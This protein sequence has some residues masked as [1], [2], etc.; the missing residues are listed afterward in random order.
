MSR[1]AWVAFAAISVI[2]GVPYLFIK[3][4]VRGG[5]AP[6]PL[7]FARVAM[8]AVLLLVLAARR[9]SLGA[10]RGRWRWL[11]AYA[12]CE[13]AG[14]FPLIAFGEQRIASSLAAILIAAVP[15][16]GALLAIRFDRSERATGSRALGL[17]VGFLGVIALMGVNVGRGGG[18]VVGT[19]AVLLAAVGY[20]IG[21]MIIKLRLAALDPAAAMGASL[22]IA[23]V[24]LAPGAAV[25][26]PQRVPSAQALASVAVLGVACTAAA[27]VIFTLLIREAGTSRALV[28]TY[29][30]PVIA[31]VLGVIALGERPSAGWIS[32][33]AAIL[34]GSWLATGG[35][36]R[37]TAARRARRRRAARVA[38]PPPEWL[39]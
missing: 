2:W 34:A 26:F 10:L 31:V 20:A 27:F 9:G 23:A 39:D 6:L 1:R 11:A 29:L 12:V 5:V 38:V 8:A 16:I 21:P 14:P 28:I 7:S 15:L 36:A 35:T 37:G 13:V 19:F 22:A 18:V 3:L 4:A 17:G 25:T 33:L 30:N 32:G 24:L